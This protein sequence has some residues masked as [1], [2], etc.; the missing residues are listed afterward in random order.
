[1]DTLRRTSS[2]QHATAEVLAKWAA[3]FADPNGEEAIDAVVALAS[4][5]I[6]C[7]SLHEAVRQIALRALGSPNALSQWEDTP[8][9]KR[10]SSVLERFERSLRAVDIASQRPRIKKERGPFVERTGW[11][12]DDVLLYSPQ[13]GP[14]I[15]LVVFHLLEGP[16]GM[17]APVVG[18]LAQ[19]GLTETQARGADLTQ[20]PFLSEDARTMALLRRTGLIKGFELHQTV[21]Q[22]TPIDRLIVIGGR[23]PIFDHERSGLCASQATWKEFDAYASQMRRLTVLKRTP[24]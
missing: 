20:I 14:S 23:R 16:N 1:L 5:Q 4:A 15:L 19:R 18:L 2:H 12:P 6:E 21:R 13:V 7:D 9:F 3:E 10:R 22:R 8:D 24:D 11:S 17:S